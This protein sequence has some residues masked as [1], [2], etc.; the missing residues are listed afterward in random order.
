MPFRGNGDRRGETPRLEVTELKEA[1]HLDR[2]AAESSNEADRRTYDL[3]ES[4]LSRLFRRDLS[5]SSGI[6]YL[7]GIHSRT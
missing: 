3:R 2:R 5:M 6:R 1:G 7:R 4:V